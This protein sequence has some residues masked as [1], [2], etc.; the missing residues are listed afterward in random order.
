M[1]V[2]VTGGTGFVGSHLVNELDERENVS[3]T[4]LS[5]EPSESTVP[6][7]DSVKRVE[8]DVTDYDSLEKAFG[9]YDVVV[10]LVA[11]SPLYKP[12]GGNIM[13]D[14][15]HRRGTENV[16]RA[17]EEEGIGKM[18]Q[19]SGVL[20]DPNGPTAYLR[21][22][23]QAEEA[24][25]DSP[26]DHVILRSTVAFGEGG[27]FI[28]FT[29]KVAPP[30][31]TPLPGGGKTRFQVIWIKDL[32]R[33]IA[34]S[35][36]EDEHNGNTYEIGG[37]NK[38]TLAE[39][40]K[41]IHASNGRSATIIPIPMPIAGIGM[42]VGGLIP[43]FPFGRDQYRSLQLDLTVDENNIDA[44]GLSEEDLR[45]FKEFLGIKKK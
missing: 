20:A 14:K 40:A 16:V 1:N 10:N 2:I 31:I 27:E 30:Y 23:G 4:A 37:P 19:M 6:I 33:M 34:D 9:D 15:V 3:V 36:L 26:L 35:A 28:P 21:A 24:V 17:A 13:H 45:D 38:L 7:P 43:M 18:V 41:L 32:V 29:K 42:T 39:I 12:K 8:G 11:L 44:F 5:R 22:K 25:R